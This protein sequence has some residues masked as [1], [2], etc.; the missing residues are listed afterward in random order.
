VGG[1]AEP[2]SAAEV[3]MRGARA[4]YV[5]PVGATTPPPVP[6]PAGAPEALVVPVGVAAP[7]VV[8]VA[9]VV[10]AGVEVAGVVVAGVE[11]V[12]VETDESPPPAVVPVAGEEFAEEEDAGEASSAP[13]VSTGTIAGG[14]AGTSSVTVVPPQA[15]SATA[16][17]VAPNSASGRVAR[18]MRSPAERTHATPARRAVVEVAL[19]QLFAP[20]AETQVLDRPGKLRLRRGE[21]EQLAD[22]LEP[23][24]GLAIGV[25]A[26]RIGLDDH[27]ATGRRGAQA[28]AI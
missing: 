28:V 5:E 26:A 15:A 9:G 22:G 10:V 8:P 1:A 25:D 27:L 19:S 2:R 11:L 17:A 12:D 14:L 6:L 20:R 3:R 24:A 18:F 23:L 7:F 13:F 4:G 16:A 21:R